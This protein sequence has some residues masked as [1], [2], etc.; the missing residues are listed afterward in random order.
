MKEIKDA[1]RQ[2]IEAKANAARKE[3]S[4][5]NFELAE[6]LDACKMF[7]GNESLEDLVALM[8]TPQGIEFLTHLGGGFPDLSVFRKFKRFSPDRSGIYIDCGEITLSN[9]ENAFLVG[10]TIASIHYDELK[11][12]RLVMMHGAKASVEASGWAVVKIDTDGTCNV[13]VKKCDHAKVL[14]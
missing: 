12:K 13:D 8:F 14:Q 9:P 4:V 2:W 3:E 7:T 6:K 5:G 1:H 11:S 10:N